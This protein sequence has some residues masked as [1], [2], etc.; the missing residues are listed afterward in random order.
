MHYNEIVI[1][2]VKR[3]KKQESEEKEYFQWQFE[4]IGYILCSLV[5]RLYTR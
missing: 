2:E 4:S 1:T 5:I 3:K